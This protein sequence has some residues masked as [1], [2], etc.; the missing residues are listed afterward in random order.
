MISFGIGY[1]RQV[2]RRQI[3]ERGVE[4]AGLKDENGGNF[5]LPPFSSF[6]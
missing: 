4:I 3:G 1:T 5:M 2:R 6:S